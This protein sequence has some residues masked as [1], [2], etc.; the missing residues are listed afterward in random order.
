M[1]KFIAFSLIAIFVIS[2]CSKS[3]DAATDNAAAGKGGSLAKFTINGNYLYIVDGTELKAYSL[4]QTGAPSLTN[5][6]DAGFIIE[7]I[8]PFGD[9]LFLGSTD[10]MFI[11]SLADP[12]K[13]ELLGLARHVRSCDPVVANDNTSYATLRSGSCGPVQEGLY[14]YDITDIRNPQQK[15][16][17]ELLTPLGLGLKENVVF[18]CQQEQ[19]MSVIDVK[20]ASKPWVMY[21]INDAVYNDVIVY[22]NLLI[23]Y[24]ST[25]LILYDISDLNHIVRTSIVKY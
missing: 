5:K 17:L 10:G 25:G 18:V 20:D 13:P 16:F 22:D 12:S 9:K 3:G 8:F 14:I 6:V 24:T 7:T 11:Y 23:C 1:K 15:G 19:G 4:E 2:G 21:S